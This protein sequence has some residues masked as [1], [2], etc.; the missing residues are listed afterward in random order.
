MLLAGNAVGAG[1]LPALTKTISDAVLE[2]VIVTARRQEENLAE[3]PV[4]VTFLGSDELAMQ[5]VLSEQDL[6][7]AAPGLT[8]RASSNSNQLN[9]AIR[10]QS[11]DA[12][13]D[14]RPGV[15]PYF[16]EIQVNGDGGSSAFYDLSSVQVLSGPQGTLFGRGATGGAVLYTSEKPRAQF[17]GYVSGT[18]GDYGLAKLEGAINSPIIADSLRGRLAGFYQS[19]RGYQ[20]NLFSH[21]DTGGFDRFGLRGSLLWVIG[22][23]FESTLVV[24]YTH[25]AGGSIVDVLWNLK[26]DAPTPAASAV[27]YSPALDAI[28]NFPGAFAAVSAAHP[29]VS[30]VGIAGDLAEQRARGPFVVNFDGANRYRSNNTIAS[31][32]TTYKFSENT[33][34]RNILGQTNSKS[35]NVS[36]ID[37]TLYLIDHND[38]RSSSSQFSEELQI[39]GKDLVG[40]LAYVA[41]SFY[42]R[43]NSSLLSL[44]GLIGIEPLVPASKQTGNYTKQHSTYAAYAQGNCDFSSATGIRG[45]SGTIGGRFTRE[46]TSLSILPADVSFGLATTGLRDAAGSIILP[47]SAFDNTQS[48]ITQNLSWTL[49]LQDQV[50]S[51]LLFYAATRRSYKNGGFNGLVS[52][53]IGLSSDGGNGF[54]TEIVT[55]VELGMKF[56]GQIAEMPARLTLAAFS[57][58]MSSAQH[59]AFTFARGNPAVITVNV[60]KARV[61]GLELAGRIKPRREI[62]VGATLNYADAEFTDNLVL[63]QG[64]P[65]F[66]GPYPDTPKTTGSVFA[67]ISKPLPGGLKLTL[68]SDMYSQ[69]SSV[70]TST[71]SNN[72]GAKLPGYSVVNFSLGVEGKPDG[73]SVTINLKNA[74]NK[75]Y[76]VG[77]VAPAE[78]LQ[79]NTAI[80]GAPRTVSF[81]GSYEF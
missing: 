65:T 66:F 28:F 26:P 49:G 45:L 23:R 4:A 46:K 33:Q 8:V 48:K 58:W 62:T 40:R 72:V 43:E 52:P 47:A 55:D 77:G 63:A 31:N 69:G 36:D 11:L 24:D 57:D 81:E 80:P 1:T 27:L 37:A 71:Q 64:I 32:I 3:T 9:F 42:S 13:S 54:A 56:Q 34:L 35:Q 74:F 44:A 12:F 73:W 41:G 79:F 61:R 60:P 51:Q 6:R 39:I 76:Y 16:D 38:L 78:V 30:P 10:G 14:T 21:R 53:V 25:F 29:G 70:F 18:F 50:N 7:I 67:E 17:G 20:Q 2:E 75:I 22:E 5:A 68:R 59:A 15:L 19:R